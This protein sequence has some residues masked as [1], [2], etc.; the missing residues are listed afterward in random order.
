VLNNGKRHIFGIK[1]GF[2]ESNFYI[3][4]YTF[5]CRLQIKLELLMMS[6]MPLETC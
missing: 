1:F 4:V 3:L 5:V 2:T 6:G